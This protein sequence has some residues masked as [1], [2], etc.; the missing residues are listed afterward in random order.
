MPL[1][2]SYKFK[3]SQLS[4]LSHYLR[5][6]IESVENWSKIKDSIVSLKALFFSADVRLALDD[7]AYAISAPLVK[8]INSDHP[9]LAK[10]AIG[11]SSIMA[12]K[13]KTYFDMY[14][15]QVCP[16]LVQALGNT[17]SVYHT[18]SYLALATIIANVKC[19]LV[20]PEICSAASSENLIALPLGARLF[21]RL[22]VSFSP[23]ILLECSSEIER[24]FNQGLLD[25]FLDIQETFL[26]AFVAYIDKLPSR[27]EPL[28]KSLPKEALEFLH[29]SDVILPAQSIQEATHVMKPASQIPSLA[30][31]I[32]KSHPIQVGS[33][34]SSSNV[35]SLIS[36]VPKLETKP[37][38]AQLSKDQIQ[39]RSTPS[40]SAA[41]YSATS[42]P[43]LQLKRGSIINEKIPD[44][45][46]VKSKVDQWRSAP[47]KPLLAI[48]KP[49]VTNS[50]NNSSQAKKNTPP[51]SAENG[52]AFIHKAMSLKS[53]KSY[54]DTYYSNQKPVID[55]Q[56]D[57]SPQKNISCSLQ[58]PSRQ[59]PVKS[60][61]NYTK[62]K[63]CES[64]L[65]PFPLDHKALSPK[66][67]KPYLKPC[68][69]KQNHKGDKPGSS[70]IP[71]DQIANTRHSNPSKN[72]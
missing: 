28:S 49:K 43:R 69:S 66:K 35:T 70:I 41:P 71:P 25:P 1:S 64:C 31:P 52:R 48:S 38:S 50:A 30:Q 55:V 53:P 2:D 54:H 11:L 10:E 14:V 45:S 62:R 13:L 60:A 3:L 63:A 7:N 4:L 5:E 40:S 57:A 47:K 37:S 21:K 32:K 12:Y 8:Y 23:N 72:M 58:V 34:A 46:H 19:V 22:I 44:Y 26:A 18:Q 56:K 65:R 20:V 9:S 27:V 24:V 61:Q 16:A 42:A 33:V 39:A 67:S 29:K 68:L 59:E 51:Q 17:N 15:C 6:A 36:S